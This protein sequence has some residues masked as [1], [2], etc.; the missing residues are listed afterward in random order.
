MPTISAPIVVADLMTS[1][2]AWTSDLMAN[3]WL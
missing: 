2:G 3:S 1:I